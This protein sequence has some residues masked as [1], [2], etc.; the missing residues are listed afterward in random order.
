MVDEKEKIVVN[1]QKDLD[2]VVKGTSI[3]GQFVQFYEMLEESLSQFTD[4]RV[5]EMKSTLEFALKEEPNL[6]KSNRNIEDLSK[7]EIVYLY[8]LLP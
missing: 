2:E 8:S 4:K 1:T 6:Y 7:L 5:E 3:D